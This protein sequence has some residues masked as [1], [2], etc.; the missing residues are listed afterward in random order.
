MTALDYY[1]TGEAANSGKTEKKA[2]IVPETLGTVYGQ[3]CPVI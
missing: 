3:S 2:K 1:I